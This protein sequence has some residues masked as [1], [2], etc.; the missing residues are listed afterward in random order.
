MDLDASTPKEATA[1]LPLKLTGK[2]GAVVADL[3]AA[4]SKT[5]TFDKVV[6]ELE[7]FTAA[8]QSGG[9][10]VD[11]FFSSGNYSDQECK[12]VVEL[13]TT[14]KE[15]LTSFKDIKDA[16]VKDIIVDNEGNLEAWRSA[17]KAVGA[18]GLSDATKAAL[19]EC[20]AAAPVPACFAHA[21]PLRLHCAHSI[22]MPFPPADK[23]ASQAA[24]HLVKK[25]AVKAAELRNV[26]SKTV[27]AVVTSAIPLSKAQ[28]EAVSKLL[29]TY[30]PSGQGVSVAFTVDPAVL[31]GLSIAIKNSIIDLSS[32]SRLMELVAT[33]K[34]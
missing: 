18:I 14:T 8:V 7:S 26:T 24:L 2:T 1:D 34:Q 17:R 4:T 19:G 6:K 21:V 32:A 11:R 28:Q 9:L 23:L 10:V 5:K 22:P 15:P 12:K 31:G 20:L 3:Y 33:Q 29:P 13:L 25:A 16:D 30:A 27:E